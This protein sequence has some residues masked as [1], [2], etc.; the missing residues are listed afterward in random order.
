MSVV[1]PPLTYVYAVER[2]SPGFWRQFVWAANGALATHPNSSLTSWWRNWQTNVEV[3]GTTDSQH[4]LGTAFDVAS[5]DLSGLESSLR[6]RGFITVRYPTHVHA[7]AW[8]A[9]AARRAG[10]F[11][12]LG[13]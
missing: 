3:G 11:D 7:Q 8:P 12:Y 2:F 9:G 6:A 4:L 5:A 13:I 1:T 10:L